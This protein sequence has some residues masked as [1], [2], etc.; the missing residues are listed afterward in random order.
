MVLVAD[1]GIDGLSK[2]SNETKDVETTHYL[3]EKKNNRV[4][5][6]THETSPKLYNSKGKLIT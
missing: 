5:V 2:Y 1:A 3:L 6:K 4:Q